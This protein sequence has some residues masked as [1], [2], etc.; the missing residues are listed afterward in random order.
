[1]LSGLALS[2]IISSEAI[3]AGPDLG[4]LRDL[5]ACIPLAYV[6]F[7]AYSCEDMERN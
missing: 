7:G 2:R 1:M 6:E 5:R 4:R 3:P